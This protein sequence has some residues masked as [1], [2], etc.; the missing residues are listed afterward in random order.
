MSREEIMLSVNK[1]LGSLEFY[2]EEFVDCVV[3][4]ISNNEPFTNEEIEELS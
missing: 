3:S 4:A 1:I 2:D